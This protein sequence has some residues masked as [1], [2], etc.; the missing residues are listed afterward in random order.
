M[1]IPFTSRV[2]GV[3]AKVAGV[4]CLPEPGFLALARPP[5]ERVGPSPHSAFL[6]ERP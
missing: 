3:A 2:R 5:V 4:P 1:K 6:H